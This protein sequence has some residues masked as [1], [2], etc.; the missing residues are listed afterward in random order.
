MK[1][2]TIATMLSTF[3]PGRRYSMASGRSKYR[4]KELSGIRKRSIRR[5]LYA[6]GF[7]EQDQKREEHW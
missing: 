6:F 2:I 3:K 5:A 1:A 4:A 7:S